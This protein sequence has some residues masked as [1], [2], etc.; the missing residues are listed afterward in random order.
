MDR[1]LRARVLLSEAETLGLTVDDLVAASSDV[2]AVESSVPTVSEY[3]A[4]IMPTFTKGDVADLPVVLAAR[5]G[6]LR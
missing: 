5:R 3:L 1:L 2:P 6:A 4:R